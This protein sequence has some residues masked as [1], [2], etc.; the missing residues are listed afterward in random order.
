MADFVRRLSRTTIDITGGLVESVT[1]IT[2]SATSAIGGAAQRLSSFGGSYEEEPVDPGL[3]SPP[4]APPPVPPPAGQPWSPA[5][6]KAGFISHASTPAN[7][8]PFI[9]HASA[10]PMAAATPAVIR[11][12]GTHW[13]KSSRRSRPLWR[14]QL[15]SALTAQQETAAEWETAPSRLRTASSQRG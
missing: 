2:V 7:K 6:S 4:K 9:S 10:F 12:R 14:H 1:D 15:P 11:R 13:R 3:M 8:K 5:P